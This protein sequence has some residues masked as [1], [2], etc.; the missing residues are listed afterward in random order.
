MTGFS[1]PDPQG[2]PLHQQNPLDRFSQRADDYGRYRPGYPAA[3]IADI[4]AGLPQPLRA[5]DVGAGTGIASRLLAEAGVQV[6][7]LE[8]NGA[9]Q[10]AAPP[11]PLVTYQRATA[12]AT[13]LMRASVDLVTCFQ[14]FHWFHPEASLEEFHRILKPGGRLALVWND[15]NEADEFTAAYGRLVRQA[16][17]D[18]YPDRE[19]R[20]FLAGME[21]SPLFGSLQ[22]H[23]YG[24]QQV[25][26]LTG[27]LGR[28]RSSSYIPQQGDIYQ[29]LVADLKH[30]YEEF[31]GDRNQV[32]LA[33]TTQVYLAAAQPV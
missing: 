29:Q 1:A 9:M 23:S 31:A 28:C 5:A 33:Y 16:A 18:R 4:L 7:A 13:E 6:M 2:L 12:E 15:R 22:H 3:A 8:P 19:N 32:T 25:L 24:Y 17:G 11:H 20:Y 27:L 21:A 10:Q 30:L 26:R 14:S